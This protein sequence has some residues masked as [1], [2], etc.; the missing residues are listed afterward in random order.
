MNT[1][2]S[3]QQRLMADPSNF[4]K[5]VPQSH[6]NN[7]LVY[8]QGFTNNYQY[9]QYLINNGA[10]IAQVNASSYGHDQLPRVNFT[11]TKEKEGKYL[12]KSAQDATKPYGYQDSDLK[13]NYLKK[14]QDKFNLIAPILKLNE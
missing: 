12:F 8:H 2:F 14:Q 1:D 7:T 3:Q 9:R 4:N 13:S 10:K 5:W 6:A 11:T